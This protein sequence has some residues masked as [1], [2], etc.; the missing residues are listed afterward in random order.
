MIYDGQFEDGKKQ[1]HGKMHIEGGTFSLESKFANDEPEFEAN[2]VHLKLPKVEAEEEVKADPKAKK[3][4]PKAAQPKP[5]D[6]KEAKNKIV[7]EIGKEGAQV[8]FELHVVFQGLPYEDPNPPPVEEKSI[9]PAKG[10][11]PAGKPAEEAKPEIRMITPDPVLMTNENGRLFE[12]ELGR[13]EKLH[14]K[15]SLEQLPAEGT[16]NTEESEEHWVNYKFN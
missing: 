6:E 15:E 16:Q 2:L 14:K 13:N 10:K 4:D 1:G 3:P 7:Y 5:E 11:A 9:A 8:E 12:I